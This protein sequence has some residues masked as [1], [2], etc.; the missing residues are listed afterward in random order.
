MRRRMVWRLGV[1]LLWVAGAG[2]CAAWA[3]GPVDAAVWGELRDAAGLGVG[4]AAV[5][6]V[7][8]ATGRV[9]VSGTDRGGKFGFLAL[10][11]GGYRASVRLGMVPVWTGAVRVWVEMGDVGEVA[12]RLS[13]GGLSLEGGEDA[14]GAG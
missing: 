14:V 2:L 8:E 6:L 4:G 3:Q 9:T 1:L 12:L 10:D 11:P 5:R 13:G 7:S